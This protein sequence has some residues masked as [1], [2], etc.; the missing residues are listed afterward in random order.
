MLR[1]LSM[2]FLIKENNHMLNEV[3]HY[4]APTNIQLYIS[5]DSQEPYPI[6]EFRDYPNV[7]YFHANNANTNLS[8]HDR[9]IPLL[10]HITTEF[11]VFRADRRHQSNAILQKQLNFLQ[12]NS[13]YSSASGVWLNEDLSIYYSLEILA[14]SGEHEDPTTR[15]ENF[16]LSFQPPYY[17]VQKIAFIKTFYEMLPYIYQKTTN[18]YYIEYFHAFLCHFIGKTKQFPNF[19]GMVQDKKKPSDYTLSDWPEIGSLLSNKELTKHTATIAKTVLK[20]NGFSTENIESAYEAYTK[21]MT[22]RFILYKYENCALAN[23]KVK[24]FGQI[25]EMFHILNKK[26]PYNQKLVEQYLRVLMSQKFDFG[27]TIHHLLQTFSPAD[28]I[29]VENIMNIIRH[30]R[31][32]QE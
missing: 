13:T 12:N 19:G 9:V 11:C 15:V 1:D 4:H 22:L 31:A 29:E 28:F 30:I 3:V 25:E 8:M 23:E 14:N 7:K 24:T 18:A 17:N 26:K 27:C 32:K 2:I 10:S 21:S 6:E 20:K 16:G 5:H